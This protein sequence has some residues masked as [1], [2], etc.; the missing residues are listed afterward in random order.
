MSWAKP[1]LETICGLLAREMREMRAASAEACRAHFSRTGMPPGSYVGTPGHDKFVGTFFD[2]DFDMS[3]GGND[4]V[5]GRAANDYFY[6][7]AAFTGRDRIDGGSQTFRDVLELNGDYS[8]GVTFGSKTLVNVEEMHLYGSLYGG[9]DYSLTLDDAT[10]ASGK[11]LQIALLDSLQQDDFL[12][13]D[14]SKEVN[15]DIWI[16]S[17][18]AA[19][20]HIVTGGG[21]DY[22]NPGRIMNDVVDGGGGWNVISLSSGPPLHVSLFLQG[23]PQD[24]GA[25]H[26]ITFDH[27][28][29][30]RGTGSGD[31]LIGDDNDNFIDGNS[32]DDTIQ[33]NGGN[34]LIWIDDDYAAVVADGGAGSNTI[35]F[36]VAYKNGVNFSLALQ[37]TAQ[38][39]GQ[40]G[41]TVNATKFADLVGADFFSDTLSGDGAAN[42]IFGG[43]G[44]D[45]LNG[46]D[47]NDSL[48][49]DALFGRNY[50]DGGH[51][52]MSGF[53]IRKSGNGKDLLNGEAGNDSLIGG[54][55]ADMLTGGSGADTFIL[56]ALGDTLPGSGN[57]DII[58]D[59]SQQQGDKIDLHAIDAD[60]TKKGNQAFQLGGSAFTGTAG[61]LIQFSGGS[62]NTILAGDVNGDSVADM[63]IELPQAI[64]LA[65]T[66]FA[67]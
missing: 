29:G 12:N 19:T 20:D 50:T 41:G 22:I 33:G 43:G 35:S 32:G 2:D 55:G 47:G 15:G 46:G 31:T 27:F 26:V 28:R 53:K 40:G 18:A 25:G 58:A 16:Q 14:A 17:T 30:L 64:T 5:K 34:D 23:S 63:E 24:V 56:Q 39:T 42:R 65:A 62:G 6:F 60:T 52:G 51:L 7:G 37:G 11:F 3:Q 61:E 66:D 57:R 10:V 21:N 45:V 59:F 49:G 54:L 9:S 8:T 48:Y 67:L 38:A 4:T 1:S 13:L 44:D 36:E